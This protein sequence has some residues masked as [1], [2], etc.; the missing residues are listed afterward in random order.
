[1]F[2][3]AG[4][5]RDYECIGRGDVSIIGSSGIT[6]GILL[7]WPSGDVAWASR[8][9][10]VWAEH[11]AIHAGDGRALAYMAQLEADGLI[12]APAGSVVP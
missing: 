11:V 12:C 3:Q 8:T 7:R 5:R 4:F 6:T 10:I 2:T 9:R 1:M